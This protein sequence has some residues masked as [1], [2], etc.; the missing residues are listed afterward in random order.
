MLLLLFL[1]HLITLSPSD[2][3][4]LSSFLRFV[5]N[6]LAQILDA[7]KSS[8]SLAL[9]VDDEG[10]GVG[11]SGDDS[12]VGV[13]GNNRGNVRF[14]TNYYNNN[15][16]IHPRF[17]PNFN[18][19]LE[20]DSYNGSEPEPRNG[21]DA[22]NETDLIINSTQIVLNLALMNSSRNISEHL[23]GK[24]SY[25][26]ESNHIIISQNASVGAFKEEPSGAINSNLIL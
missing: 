14:D 21:D 7:A 3:L 17:S 4:S 25:L 11:L 5:A 23:A 2:S 13:K 16:E 1:I 26:N 15:R 24:G 12:A 19:F 6:F 9:E 10:V 18:R 8:G 20:T 22:S